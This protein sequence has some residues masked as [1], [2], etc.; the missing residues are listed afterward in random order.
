MKAQQTGQAN[1]GPTPRFQ[2][3]PHCGRSKLYSR[4][5]IEVILEHYADE[6]HNFPCIS[7]K[8]KQLIHIGERPHY[9]LIK[10]KA[11]GAAPAASPGPDS[12]AHR[13]PSG[14]SDRVVPAKADEVPIPT[15][16][17]KTVNFA[18]D[19]ISDADTVARHERNAADR[20][21]RMLQI[22]SAIKE[23][24]ESHLLFNGRY[25]A[26]EVIGSG[27]SGVV[28]AAK[29]SKTGGDVALKVH[30]DTAFDDDDAQLPVMRVERSYGIQALFQSSH[31]VHPVDK[32]RHPEFGI[33][34]VERYIRAAPLEKVLDLRSKLSE[35]D[36]VEIWIQLVE[37]LIEAHGHGVV[38]RDIKPAN[39]MVQMHGDKPHV[40][41]ID[42]GLARIKKPVGSNG[43]NIG[44]TAELSQNELRVRLRLKSKSKP[45]DSHLQTL[46]AS[47]TGKGDV[48]GTPRYMSPEQV[49]GAVADHRSDQYG[50]AATIYH[51][52]TG[53]PPFGGDSAFSIMVNVICGEL[54]PAWV[55]AERNGNPIRRELSNI[56]M[57]ALSR[58][59]DARFATPQ[60]LLDEL[61]A[62]PKFS[63]DQ[64]AVP[65]PRPS[66][67][68]MRLSRSPMRI[69]PW[70]LFLIAM[71]LAVATY[72][73]WIP[74]VELS[75]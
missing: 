9:K 57:K 18:S 10:G 44:G 66:D 4:E 6:M 28:I 16:G 37:V 48:L 60:E 61:K 12:K 7:S 52:V 20:Q 22:R 51:V 54:E 24:A 43:S 75:R 72:M 3:C 25:R 1:P 34:T 50:L 67:Q 56:L 32:F 73:G 42:W 21:L 19:P 47:L 55:V 27:A 62:L 2:A 8:C 31:V 11:T 53:S 39:V 49:E 30:V 35:S 45:S 46:S 69:L 14:R 36:A 13:R 33:I 74:R 68:T 5:D 17:E 65:R 71:A 23:A 58:D 64:P 40:H 59:P 29:D 26:A 63:R 15:S 41:L 70:I 38:H